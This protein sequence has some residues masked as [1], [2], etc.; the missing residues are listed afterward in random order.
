MMTTFDPIHAPTRTITSIYIKPLKK[1]FT[2]NQELVTENP[3]QSILITRVERTTKNGDGAPIPWLDVFVGDGVME[4]AEAD[5][6]I[7]GEEHA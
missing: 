2:M 1:T 6:I 7:L 4:V 3:G 5:C